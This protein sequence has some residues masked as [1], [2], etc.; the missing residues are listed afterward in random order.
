MQSLRA[1]LDNNKRGCEVSIRQLLAVSLV[2][3][4]AG[5]VNPYTQFYTGQQDA[6]KMPSYQPIAQELQI[7]STSDFN[8][9]VMAMQA[10]GYVPIGQS[11][12]IAPSNRV[13]DAQLRQQAETVGAH[14]V[15]VSSSYADTVTGAVPINIPQTSRS[16][17]SGQATAYGAGGVVNAYGTSNTTTYGSQTVMM[18]YSV[19]RAN[20]GAVFMAKVK[21]LLGIFVIPL[22]TETHRKRGSNLGIRANVVIE[23]S[24]AYLADVFP[25]DILLKLGDDDIQSPEQY[26]SLLEKYAGK[27]VKL[28]LERDDKKIEKEVT[29][30]SP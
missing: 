27:T 30:N 5:C 24:P 29:L 19:G 10:R 25:G 16:F 2:A 17:T 1:D 3:L 23:G 7:Y 28:K 21:S 13:S 9:D 4:L 11:F 18:P 12:F 22:D 15:L 20:Y 26:P 8:K 6:R 14:A